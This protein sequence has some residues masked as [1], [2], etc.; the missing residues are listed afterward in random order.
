[1]RRPVAAVREARRRAVWRAGERWAE[2]ARRWLRRIPQVPGVP[3]RSRPSPQRPVRQGRQIW[4]SAAHFAGFGA[5]I[6][7]ICPSDGHFAESVRYVGQICPSDRHFVES[8]TLSH[9]GSGAWP[10]GLHRVSARHDLARFQ[11]FGAPR[12]MTRRCTSFAT[13]MIASTSPSSTSTTPL[14]LRQ[15]ALAMGLVEHAPL[16]VG[17]R[18]GVG[19][20][21]KDQV[22]TLGAIAMPAQRRQRQRVR[23][24]VGQVEA[25]LEIQRGVFCILQAV[26][27]RPQQALELGLRGRLG[28]DLA[29]AGEPDAS[30]TLE[31]FRAHRAEPPRARSRRPPARASKTGCPASSAGGIPAWCRAWD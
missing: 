4:R 24:V 3:D 2:V 30:K 10:A 31:C 13:R 16:L 18:D 8:V 11:L 20:A 6:G 15:I 7:Q 21:L 26:S 5:Y 1:M 29:D 23:R 27:T 12:A 28:L 22:A 14:V 9:S 25:T 19:Q 17:Q